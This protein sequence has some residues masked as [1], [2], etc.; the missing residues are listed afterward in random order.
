[1]SNIPSPTP[2]TPEEVSALPCP[3]NDSMTVAEKIEKLRTWEMLELGIDATTTYMRNVLFPVMDFVID[4]PE[5]IDIM[6]ESAAPDLL[7]RIFFEPMVTASQLWTECGDL[8]TDKVLNWF[9]EQTNAAL[10]SNADNWNY[11]KAYTAFGVFD[12]MEIITDLYEK[13]IFVPEV[14]LQKN[15]RSY[16]DEYKELREQVIMLYGAPSE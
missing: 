3:I 2:M 14:W 11:K 8:I 4:H 6:E 13:G 9:D 1:M 15:G 16:F 10:G 5:V 12:N 7:S